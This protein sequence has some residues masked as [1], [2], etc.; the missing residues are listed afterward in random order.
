[1][2]LTKGEKLFLIRRR[3]GMN[4]DVFGARWGL[5]HDRLTKLER[6]IAPMPANM[7]PL[8]ITP[9]E[10]ELVTVMRRRVGWTLKQF[11]DHM[12]VSHVTMI[13]VEKGRTNAK[14]YIKTLSSLL[15]GYP[16]RRSA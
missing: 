2:R 3:R 10:G 8:V 5:T 13:R 11:A 12:Q 7:L 15:A 9:T 16:K 6:D 4:Q 1:M 14:P